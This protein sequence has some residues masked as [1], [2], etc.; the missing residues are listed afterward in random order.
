MISRDAS[1]GCRLW[2]VS[3]IHI[4]ILDLHYSLPQDIVIVT[5]QVTISCYTTS[6]HQLSQ[7]DQAQARAQGHQAWL[8]KDGNYP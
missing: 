1:W 2:T 7:H 5:L 3:H 4:A 6:P 8:S